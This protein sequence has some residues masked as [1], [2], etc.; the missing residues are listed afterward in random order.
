MWIDIL[1]SPFGNRA[2]KVLWIGSTTGFAERIG[3]AIAEVAVSFD[4]RTRDLQLDAPKGPQTDADVIFLEVAGPDDAERFEK[5]A[6]GRRPD[7]RIV[8]V[9]PEPDA[10]ILR[11]LIRLGLSDWLM[12]DASEAEIIEACQAPKILN[13]NSGPRNVIVFTPVLGG[14]GAT[15]LAIEA[16]IQLCK[17]G[18][19]PTCIVD[20]DLYA[21]ECADFLNI[22][23]KLAIDS[24]AKSTD[25]IDEHLLDSVLAEH[26]SGIKLLAAQTN[27]S[28]NQV[29]NPAAVVHLLNLVSSVFDHVIIDMPRAWQPWTDDVILGSDS[30]FLVSDSSVPALRA[31]R[32]QIDEF[33]KR[34][35]GK[36][37]P[38]VIVNKYD[39]AWFSTAMREKDLEASLGS[40]FAGTVLDETKLAR[41]AIDR[42]VPIS[43]LKK[44]ATLVK[45]LHSIMRKHTR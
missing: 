33:S 17:G 38:H 39:R 32:R 40:S 37:K 27:M 5:L 18:R 9:T 6:A 45:D 7:Q 20:L 42:G 43:T 23:A 25:A 44:N 34:Y 28:A 22:Q 12:G 10:A 31:A 35:A 36:V 2:L 14:M 21:G 19:E 1:N 13:V 41:E 24:L 8:A 3:K 15:T 4:Q 26:P 16:A 11:R 30:I 29:I